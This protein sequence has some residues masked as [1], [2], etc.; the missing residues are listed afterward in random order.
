[1]PMAIAAAAILIDIYCLGR[2]GDDGRYDISHTLS[3]AMRGDGDMSKMGG[4][5]RRWR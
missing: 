3:A 1:M 4:D 5:A 2:L